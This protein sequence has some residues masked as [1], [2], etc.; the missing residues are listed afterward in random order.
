[1]EPPETPSYI[2]KVS[3]VQTRCAYSRRNVLARV[4]GWGI[5]PSV[6]RKT[7]YKSSTVTMARKIPA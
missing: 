1:M 4:V 5:K 3:A 6:T 7:R 2:Y